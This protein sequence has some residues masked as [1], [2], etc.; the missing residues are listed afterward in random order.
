MVSDGDSKE[1]TAHRRLT[2]ISEF[3]CEPL[4]RKYEVRTS[5]ISQSLFRELKPHSNAAKNVN[6]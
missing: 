5:S 6:E 1:V 4:R 3:S 2:E